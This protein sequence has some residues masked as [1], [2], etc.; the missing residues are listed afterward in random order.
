MNIPNS[1]KVG[2]G[3]AVYINQELG[4]SFRL[5][6]NENI[7]SIWLRSKESDETVLGFFYCSPDYGDSDFSEIIQDEIGKFSNNRN[8]FIF[9]DFNA[10]TK[11][12]CENLIHDKYDAD[13][14][15]DTV[16]EELPL[17]RNSEDMKLINYRGKEFLP[18]S[19]LWDVLASIHT[20][21]EGTI[22]GQ[23][24]EQQK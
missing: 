10:R 20:Y 17:S 24:K 8:T 3:I 22:M 15:L 6:P 2:G 5:I 9:G 11:N 12:E 14:G 19:K 18:P 23:L 7:D 1:P 4:D 21:H 16:M 13:I